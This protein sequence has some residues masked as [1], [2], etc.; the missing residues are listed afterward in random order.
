MRPL[1]LSAISSVFRAIQLRP[2]DRNA[3]LALGGTFRHTG[4]REPAFAGWKTGIVGNR[5]IE[6]IAG[7][8]AVVF[9]AA[10]V[11]SDF[12]RVPNHGGSGF[13]LSSTRVL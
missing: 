5:V 3:A 4:A 2:L 8:A 9:I 1:R 10:M 12:A 7:V 11:L 6:I 13:D